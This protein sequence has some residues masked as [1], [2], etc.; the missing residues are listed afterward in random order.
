MEIIKRG[1]KPS[2]RT[3]AGTCKDCGTRVKFKR[4]EAKYHPSF[5]SGDADCLSVKCP[6]CGV[7]IWI[8]I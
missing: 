7:E 2:D 5:R 8:E 3:Y 6:E 4:S 1:K